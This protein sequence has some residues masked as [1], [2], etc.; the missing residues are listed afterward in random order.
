MFKSTNSAFKRLAFCLGIFLVNATALL[1]TPALAAYSAT[2]ESLSTTGSLPRRSWNSMT[3][4]ADRDRIV[5]WGGW[6][7]T[8][9]NDMYEFDPGARDWQ[10]VEPYT[11]C[12]GNSGFDVPNGSDESGVAYDPINH[13]L[14]I[15]NAGSGYRCAQSRTAGA[16]T[17]SNRVVDTTLSSGQADFYKDFLVSDLTTV[18][19]VTAYDP[20]TRTLYLDR[21]L[22]L[23]AGATYQL[24]A[25]PGAGTWSYDFNSGT[26]VKLESRHWGY[27]GPLPTSIG[28]RYAPGFAS[29]GSSYAILFGGVAAYYS[30]YGA[31][32]NSTWKLDFATKSYSMMLQMSPSG[33]AARGEIQNQFVYDSV[34]DR[35]VLFGGRCFDPARCG[36]YGNLLND[37]W[38]YNAQ[39]NSWTQLNPVT[40]PPGRQMGQMYFDASLGLVVLY[41]G[42]GQA[43]ILDDLWIL[44]VGTGTWTQLTTTNPRVP[45]YLASAAF[46]ANT[47]CGYLVDGNTT[48]GASSS[49][50]YEICLSSSGGGTNLPPLPNIAA[51]PASGPMGTV[52]TFLGD[53]SR[54]PDGTIVSY[55]WDLGDGTKAT[56]VSVSKTYAAPGN[57]V[58]KLTVT[59]NLGA[60]A[61]DSATVTVT[62]PTGAVNVALA[63]NGGVATASSTY[64]AGYSA[65]GANDGDR[66]GLNWA[67]GGGWNDATAG[68][69]PDWLQVTFN[70]AKTIGEIDVFTVQDNYSTVDP[71]ALLTFS[72][73]GI[74][75]FQVQYW[76]GSAWVDVPG[77]SVIGNN[78][79]WRKFTF[80]AITTDRIRV[81]VTGALYNYARIVELEAWTAGSSNVAPTVTLTGPANGAS[82]TLGGSF[83]LTATAADA[84]GT[85]AKVEFLANG[86]VIGQATSAPYAMT[87]TPAA[88]GSY[89]LTARATDNVGAATTSAAATV[90]V[91]APSGA[92]NV[93]L[94]SNGAVATASSTYS[95]GY[96]AAGAN[97]GDRKG[98]NWGNGGG[99][100]DATA[101]AYP[102]WL[103][104]TFSG[105]KTIGEIDVFTV[106]DNYWAPVTP[107]ASLT[108]SQYGI[109]DFRAQ[110][111][112]GS[113]WVDVPGGSVTSNNL[114][115]R[116][117]TFSAITTDRIRVLVTGALYNYARIVELEAWT[118]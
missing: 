61:T 103:Q 80:S 6:G 19:V 39:T 112:T 86:S 63:S 8:F 92:V 101:G 96:S 87:W 20:A 93:A 69:Y 46:A 65:A 9:M 109:T 29:N 11:N 110:Y 36:Y 25:D 99:W 98:L 102:D 55:S 10:Q 70:G 5:L 47:G 111:W 21:S 114:V 115:W 108:F 54:D 40:R 4:V 117:F 81:L 104:V 1:G 73:Y 44:D 77:G 45:L 33:P 14:W 58:A 67:N 18:A 49:G 30:A 2:W 88:T 22:S 3:W 89:V 72:Q 7:S 118:P 60:T 28:I 79:V 26:Y 37:T 13:L 90:T 42:Q 94:A 53:T 17:S 23:S 27:A 78:L 59:D 52:F 100:N 85:V 57:Y 71:T 95:A 91:T 68:A 105:A 31:Y 82:T 107:T 32:D 41:G 64:S 56:G 74:T 50:I 48:G 35:F 62:A 83:A 38:I 43:A 106:Q 12:P 113:A 76:N 15:Y 16:G 24:Y 66:K 75:D 51:S 84:D 34:H 97:D 116:K